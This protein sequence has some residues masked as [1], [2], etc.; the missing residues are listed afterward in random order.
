MTHSTSPALHTND[1]VALVENTQLDGIANAP[2]ETLVNILLPWRGLEVG[3]LLIVVEGVDTTIQV[4]VARGASVA[5]DHDD[6]ADWTVFG[7]EAGGITPEDVLAREEGMVWERGRGRWYS[8]GGQDENGSS[9][10]LERSRHGSHGAVLGGWHRSWCKL[11]QLIVRVQVRDG[12]LSQQTCLV[13]HGHSLAWVVALGSLA[14]QHDTVGAIQNSI[15]HIADLGTG[16]AW[17]VGHALQHLS[18]ANGG[19][20]G[21]VALG[22]HH[23]LCNENLGGRDLDTQITTSHHDTVGD[24]E[25]LVKVVDS[26]LVLNLGDDLDVLALLTEH[27]TDSG[28]VLCATNKRGKD[29]VHVVLDTKFQIG[30]VLFAQSG[31]IDVCLG[32]VDTLLAADLAVVDR[33][34]L[35]C[36]VVHHLQHLESEHTVVDVDG[37]ALFNDLGDVLVVDV[38]VLVVGS[39]SIL[40]VCGDVDLGACGN[41]NVLVVWSVS[42]A[43]LGTLGVEGD[44]DRAAFLGGLGLAGVVNDGLVVL[45]AAVREV[46]ADDLQTSSAEH[47]DLL[48]RVG[49]GACNAMARVSGIHPICVICL[50]SIS[51]FGV[52]PMVQMMEVRLNCFGGWYS[53]LRDASHC[54]RV[55]PYSWCTRE[56]PMMLSVRGGECVWSV[57]SSFARMCGGG[58][59][60]VEEEVVGAAT[61]SAD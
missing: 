3:L 29:H 38:H 24:L 27:L 33:L 9:V 4:G 53:V 5:C 57:A 20:A 23:L 36:L 2:L 44:G 22:D 59:V 11:L 46:H 13:H 35:Q 42:G 55:R 60:F 34:A 18:G 61:F 45:V 1:R 12:N 19:L 40:V 58:G 32:Q 41:G 7:D 39:G 25:D 15:A 56:S 51:L 16:G 52:I 48:G 37:A 28:D 30:L 8:R 26:L 50:I 43:D 21:N 49:L 6:G 47:V 54:T 17:V 31:E 10:L 14:R